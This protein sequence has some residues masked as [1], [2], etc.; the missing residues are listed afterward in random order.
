MQWLGALDVT[1]TQHICINLK[2]KSMTCAP[3]K[4][5]LKLDNFLKLG[6]KISSELTTF[7]QESCEWIKHVIIF[8]LLQV[9]VCMYSYTCRCMCMCVCMYSYTCRCMCMHHV[10][11]CVH[12]HTSL[13]KPEASL[14]AHPVIR[15]STSHRAWSTLA[16]QCVPRIQPSLPSHYSRL[17]HNAPLFDTGLEPR[18]S[19]LYNM[20]FT[21]WA[22][23]PDM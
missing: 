20:H 8:L 5:I 7:P 11:I 4:T 23:S 17:C 18:S 19:C 15:H 21:N 3:T 22:I 2:V 16:V 1:G 13:R 14:A 12:V 9:Y 10:F 6:S